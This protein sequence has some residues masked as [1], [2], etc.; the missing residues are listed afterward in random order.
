MPSVELSTTPEKGGLLGHQGFEGHMAEPTNRSI[1][2]GGL[3]EHSECGRSIS[4]IIGGSRTMRLQRAG[5]I[6]SR[7]R[8]GIL[9]KS[10]ILD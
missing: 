1:G 6:R 5:N 9:D 2:S 3:C 7:G 8:K 10:L 4:R